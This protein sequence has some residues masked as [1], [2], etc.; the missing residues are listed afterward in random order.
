[1]FTASL[2][3]LYCIGGLSLFAPLLI[4]Q[5]DHL[6]PGRIFLGV[7]LS[8]AEAGAALELYARSAYPYRLALVCAL[9]ALALY[10]LVAAIMST[11]NKVI[12]RRLGMLAVALQ[13][14]FFVIAASLLAFG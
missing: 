4:G 14:I 11:G 12:Y 6:G 13:G 2:A 1:M 10:G 3:L 8:C 7:L 9:L 5:E